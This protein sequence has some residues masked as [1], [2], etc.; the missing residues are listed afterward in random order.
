MTS[1]SPN[2]TAASSLMTRK[3]AGKP[4][5][6]AALKARGELDR[7]RQI[8]R[9]GAAR[10]VELKRNHHW[11]AEEASAAGKLG[12]AKRTAHSLARRAALASAF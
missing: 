3:P 5:G 9:A 6:F 12:A 1:A 8:A 7:V 2:T 11:T 10:C 4:R